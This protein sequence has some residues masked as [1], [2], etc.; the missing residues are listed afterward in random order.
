VMGAGKPF[1]IA[2]DGPAA[3]G[4]S[5]LALALAR[6]LGLTLVDSGAMYR[7]VTLIAL[8][9]DVVMH[10]EKALGMIAQSVSTDF[11]IEMPVDSPPM[12]MIGDRDITQEIRSVEVGDAVSEISRVGAVRNEL[13]RLQRSM[14]SGRG[15]VVEGRDIGTAVFPDAP[16]KVFLQASL[17]ERARRRYKELKRRGVPMSRKYVTEEIARRDSID[18]SRG[19]S[20]MFMASDAFLLDTTGMRVEQVVNSIMEEL[21][22][23]KLIVSRKRN[24]KGHR[25]A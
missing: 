18:T 4:K 6:R 5:S 7:A 24:L 11:R 10:N 20:P 14:V 2:I 15:A 17:K 12:I 1:V 13:V 3:S 9:R 23:R 21:R 22:A 16:L 19:L 25:Q 8:E